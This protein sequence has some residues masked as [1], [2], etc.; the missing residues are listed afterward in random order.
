MSKKDT[1]EPIYSGYL[2]IDSMC[3]CYYENW[4]SIKLSFIDEDRMEKDRSVT[5][6]NLFA[7]NPLLYDELKNCQDLFCRPEVKIAYSEL[8]E[9]IRKEIDDV[10]KKSQQMDKRSFEF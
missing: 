6:E 4:Y 5:L 10:F 1:K 9:I 8:D 7:H 2:T 3:A